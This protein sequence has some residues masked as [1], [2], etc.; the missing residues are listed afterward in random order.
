VAGAVDPVE[1]Q[2][3]TWPMYTHKNSTTA[4]AAVSDSLVNSGVLQR[5]TREQCPASLFPRDPGAI[6]TSPVARRPAWPRRSGV[7]M[8]CCI[9]LR[10]ASS[11]MRLAPQA[12]PGR[13]CL[14]II[15]SDLR[16]PP[17]A[18]AD[19]R[20]DFRPRGVHRLQTI[21]VCIFIHS[22][23]AVATHA[24][25]AASRCA[26]T[27]YA[28]ASSSRNSG[29]GHCCWVRYSECHIGDGDASAH[30]RRPART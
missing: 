11:W 28:L 27:T 2:P 22:C 15:A 9:R 21:P 3:Q 16:R 24:S 13:H 26:I 14:S 19:P 10:G 30:P 7:D 29:V 23:L 20:R 1:T 18:H 8:Q 17:L 5:S 4:V 6:Q 12:A 25:A